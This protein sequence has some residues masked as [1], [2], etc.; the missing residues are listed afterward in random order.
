MN[1]KDSELGY[2]EG[3]EEGFGDGKR[4]TCV[5][6]QGILL[7][8]LSKGSAET[9]KDLIKYFEGTIDKI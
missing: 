8:S 9:L 4:F 7:R 3:Y 2:D 6:V 5:E 1:N